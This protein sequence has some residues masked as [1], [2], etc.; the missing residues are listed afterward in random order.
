MQMHGWR[1]ATR[2]GQQVAIHMER[3]IKNGAAT[4]IDRCDLDAGQMLRATGNDHGMAAKNFDPG[5][6]GGFHQFAAEVPAQIDE[7]LEQK[8]VEAALAAFA[9]LGCRDVARIDLR[10]DASGEPNFIECN[11][12]PGLNPGFSDL[13]VIAE[14]AGMGHAALVGAILAPAVRRMKNELAAGRTS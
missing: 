9:A 4:L 13:C 7:A 8:L 10:L 14:S 11:P 2:H 6:M 12:L 1:Q 5:S 3:I